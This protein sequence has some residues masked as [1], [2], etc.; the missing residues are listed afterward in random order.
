MTPRCCSDEDV[1]R[2]LDALDRSPVI[3][4]AAEWPAGLDDLDQPG[5]YSWWVDDSGAADLA[6]ALDQELRAGRIYAGQTGAT[7]WPSGRVG[8]MT[9]RQRLGGNHLRGSIRGSTFRTLGACLVEPLDPALAAAGKLT[10]DS[11]RQLSS[12]MQ[13]HLRVAVHPYPDRDALRDLERRVLAGLDPPL[14]LEG[15]PRTVLRE[16]LSALR[17][18]LI[19]AHAPPRRSGTRAVSRDVAPTT[20]SAPRT[21]L[22]E[23]IATILRETG[24]PMTTAELADAVN[25]RG[26]YTKRDKSLVTSFQIHGRT[27]NYPRLFD[28]DGQMVRLRS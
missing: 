10:P 22:H 28:R 8:A 16:R 6:A 2:A 12:W 23:E 20:Q 27:R 7:K 9:L 19:E 13:S 26:I 5:L 1:A 11:E 17:R 25:E 18:R 24:R 3:V 15:M 21:T 14:N 4:S